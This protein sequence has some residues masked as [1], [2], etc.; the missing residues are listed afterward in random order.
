WA[1]EAV[2][3]GA[4]SHSVDGLVSRMREAGEL[5]RGIG[6]ADDR[7]LISRRLLDVA[8]RLD[9]LRDETTTQESPTAPD[10]PAGE[11]VP[12]ESLGFDSEIGIVPVERLAPDQPAPE[13]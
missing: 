4:A 7:M 6:E 10:E 5:L 9:R 2:G 8:H 3:A 13:E 12:I 11:P 1:R